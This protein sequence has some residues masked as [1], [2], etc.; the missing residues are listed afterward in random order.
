MGVCDHKAIMDF[1]ANEYAYPNKLF[2]RF[3]SGGT[4]TTIPADK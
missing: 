1:Y 4:I 2:D 3:A